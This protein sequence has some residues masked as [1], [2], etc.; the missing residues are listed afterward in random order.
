LANMM[1]GLL[2]LHE[3]VLLELADKRFSLS[4]KRVSL[5]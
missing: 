3:H 5:C 1:I 4:R 2:R